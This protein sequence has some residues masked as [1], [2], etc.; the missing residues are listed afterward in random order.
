MEVTI[1][2]KFPGGDFEVMGHPVGSGIGPL[3]ARCFRGSHYHEMVAAMHKLGELRFLGRDHD[4]HCLWVIMDHVPGQPFEE[5]QHY[6][7]AEN[8]DAVKKNADER[9]G[10]ARLQYAQKYDLLHN[11]PCHEQFYL[12]KEPKEPS[13]GFD[14]PRVAGWNCW[15]EP[16]RDKTTGKISKEVEDRIV[17]MHHFS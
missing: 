16:P 15:V 1:G 10:Q 13:K 2:K 7:N 11:D 3:A 17:K 4:S 9:M 14:V 12:F 6:L 8:K 5:T